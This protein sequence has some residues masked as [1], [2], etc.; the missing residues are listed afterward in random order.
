MTDLSIVTDKDGRYQ[1]VVELIALL[2]APESQQVSEV[3]TK[4]W[5]VVAPDL[6]QEHAVQIA[7]EAK[8]VALPVVAADGTPVG[9]IPPFWTCS[10]SWPENIGKIC[11]AW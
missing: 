2:R 9:I 5:P 6:D 7:D 1:G 8:V 4:T 3:L 10:T 11:I